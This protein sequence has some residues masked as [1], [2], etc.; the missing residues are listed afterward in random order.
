MNLADKIRKIEAL[1]ANTSSEGERRA[2]ELAKKR[3]REKTLS[4]PVEYSI[5]TDGLWKK[6]LLMAL[7]QKHGLTPYRYPGQKRTTIRVRVSRMFMDQVVWPEYLKYAAAFD[8]LAFDIMNDLVQKI[9]SVHEEDEI[10]ISGALPTKDI[11][12]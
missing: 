8:E 4:Q 12:L 3:L 1:I 9:H 10:E 6:R 5:R 11:P 2:A 7:C